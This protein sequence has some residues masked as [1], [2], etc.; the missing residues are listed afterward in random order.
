[1]KTLINSFNTGEV[2]PLL[3]GRVDLENLRR[4]CRKLRNFIPRVFGG[5]F[6]RPSLLHLETALLPN[7]HCRL[8][9]FVFSASTKFQIEAGHRYLRIFEANHGEVVLGDDLDTALASPWQESEVDEIQ[10]VQVNDVM[11][12]SHPNHPPQEL[13]RKANNQWELRTLPWATEGNAYPPMS[14]EN[15][16]ATTLRFQKTV[17]GKNVV[18]SS[19]PLFVDE[20][21]GSFWQIGHFREGLSSELKFKPPERQSGTTDTL[22]L[23]THFSTWRVKSEGNWS[24]TLFL[25]IQENGADSEYSIHEQW[26]NKAGEQIS[27]S[28]QGTAGIPNVVWTGRYRLRVSNATVHDDKDAGIYLDI[29]GDGPNNKGT[30]KESRAITLK[31]SELMSGFSDE[32]RVTGGWEFSTYGRWSGQVFVEQ[33]NA[34]GNWDVV[35]RWTGEMDRNLTASGTV[36]R[37]ETMRVRAIAMMAAPASDAAGPRFVLECTHSR[38]YGLVKVTAREN[39][40]KVQVQVL[41]PVWNELETTNW[42]EG[43][44]S[45]LR[46]YPRAVALHEQRLIFAGTRKEPQTIWGSVSADFRNF[47]QTGRDDGAFVYQIAAQE[48]NPISWMASQDGLIIGTEGDEWLLDGNDRAITPNNVRTKRQ[49]RYGSARIQALMAGSTVL[50]IQRGGL[51]LREYIFQ[52]EQ[53]NFVAPD[54]SQLAQHL[55]HGGVRSFAYSQN[56]EQLIWVVTQDGRLLTCTYRREEKVIAWAEHPTAGKVE[57]VSVVHGEAA[58]GDEVWFVVRRGNKRCIERLHAAHWRLLEEGATI[59]HL[60]A[61]VVQEADEGFSVV[62]GLDHLNGQLVSIVTDGVEQ[63]QATVVAGEVM[64]PE[65]TRN[66]AVGLPAPALLQPMPL[67]LLL[68]DGTAQGRRF[69]IKDLAVQLYHSLSGSYAD[70]DDGSVYDLNFRTVE[71]FDATPMEPFTGLLRLKTSARY[72]DHLETQIK[73][74]SAMPLN[75]LS[76]IPN[77]EIYGN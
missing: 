67:E 75:I 48:S 7:R 49:S 51:A 12:L 23:A 9:P 60:D 17:D 35:R 6:R 73:T 27:A 16:G 15:L 59:W 77:L 18:H 66:A 13:L 44:W 2:S 3:V 28:G 39:E 26:E 19:H 31:K 71:N 8:I 43:A 5:A 74:D 41:R 24:G 47:E 14:D 56:P 29:V 21:V 10:Y 42:N 53:Q 45:D 34:A 37:E 70:G 20:H 64:V 22:S 11:F 36:D 25:E 38:V 68:E 61:A 50:F 55:F 65:G 1:M 69:I 54:V 76:L 58:S 4:A 57:S 63:G 52:W 30:I 46:G 72:R 40:K 62:G 32:L 33:K